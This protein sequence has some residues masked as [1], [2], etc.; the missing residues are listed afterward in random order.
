MYCKSCN[1]QLPDYAAFCPNCGTPIEDDSEATGLLNED[2]LEDTGLL[3]EEEENTG[4][5]FEE[6]PVNEESPFVSPTSFAS[7]Q[8][9]NVNPAFVNP[10]VQ[11]NNFQPTQYVQQNSTSANAQQV[12]SSVQNSYTQNNSQTVQNGIMSYV[13]FYERFAS[14]KTKNNTKAIGIICIITAVL[15]LGLFGMG[16]FISI[17]D[18]LFYS[19]FAGLILKL[20][21]WTFTLPV[22]MY[23]GIFTILGLAL[24][25]TPSGIVA[26]I[27]SIIATVQLKKLNDAYNLYLST[28]QFPQT[29]I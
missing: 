15:S 4:L 18:V 10:N 23:G 24:S 11:T 5:L 22:A 14:K 17:I 3:I 28:N 19:V 20:K 1:A 2:V 16:N 13:D 25:G 27:V 7:N 12:N 26:F 29:E 6:K 21:K 8:N 9:A